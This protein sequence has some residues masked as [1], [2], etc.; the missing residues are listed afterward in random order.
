MLAS[1]MCAHAA[2]QGNGSNSSYSRFGLGTLNDQSVGF[3]KAMGGVGK[4]IRPTNR[5]NPGNPASYS[6]V[7]SLTM[8][9]DGGMTFSTGQYKQ[10]GSTLKVNNCSFD[11]VTA[12]FRL[13]KGLGFSLGMLPYTT[14]GYSFATESKVTNDFNTTQTITSHSAFSGDGGLHQLYAGVGWNPFAALSIGVNV[15]YVWGSYSHTLSQTFDEGGT[16]SGLYSGLHSD[17]ES[18]IQTYKID[19]GLQYPIILNPQN[20]LTVGATVGLGH[21]INGTSTLTRYN[22]VGDTVKIEAKDAFDLPYTLGA[23]VAWESQGK[24][25]VALDYTYEKWSSCH[26]PEQTTQDDQLAYSKQKGQYL[27][28]SR[29]AAGFQYVPNP[30]S[31]N[32]LSRVEY[33]LGANFSTP[34]LKVNGTDGPREYGVTAGFGLPISNK[35][36]RGTMANLSFQWFRRSPAASSLIREDY[37]MVS[38]GV[39]FSESWF[40][41]FKIQ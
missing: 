40:M 26:T 3:N 20:R 15:G 33:R 25:M 41:K 11:Y 29:V 18:D 10:G 2:A 9:I 17:C 13:R 5:I 32:Y 30:L 39:T 22:T 28:R 8:L 14:I 37:F 27:D 7:D 19:L 23:G 12:G 31:R 21:S 34:Y 38:V 6:A 16:T 4:A 1:L 24:M 36:N 35:I